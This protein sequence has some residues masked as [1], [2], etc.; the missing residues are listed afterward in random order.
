MNLPKPDPDYSAV[1]EG[2]ARR[3]LEE[4]DRENMKRGR[5][6]V[7]QPGQR[8]IWTAPDGSQHAVGVDNAG[9]FTSTAYP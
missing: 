5:D 9:A 8:L 4:A 3:L 2:E 6:I 7:I 1:N